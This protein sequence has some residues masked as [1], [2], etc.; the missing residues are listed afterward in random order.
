MTV[1]PFKPDGSKEPVETIRLPEIEDLERAVERVVSDLA[2][3]PMAELGMMLEKLLTGEVADKPQMMTDVLRDVVTAAC[4]RRSRLWGESTPWE[5]WD[6]DAPEPAANDTS[7][8]DG[9]A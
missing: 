1:I 6:E 9:V 8:P 7:D 5:Q 4:E 2:R 3:R